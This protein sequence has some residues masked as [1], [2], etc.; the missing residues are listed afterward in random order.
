ME[1]APEIEELR[2]LPIFFVVGMGRSGTT[3]LRTILDAHPHTVV[4]VESKFVIHLKNKYKC[5]NQWTPAL[6]ENFII[7]LYG[8]VKFK[9]YWEMEYE[10]LRAFILQYDCK[11]LDFSLLCKMVYFNHASVFNKGKPMIIGD[12]NPVYSLFINDLKEVF[13]DAKF[14]HLVRDY[15]DTIVSN[16]KY[17]QRKN[18][19]AL[20]QVWA[21]YN[22]NIED[23][24]RH[25]R[26]KFYT[27]RYEDLVHDP[28]I[29]VKEICHFLGIEFHPVMLEFYLKTR[30]NYGDGKHPVVGL[31]F[32][33]LLN[34]VNTNQ[35]GKWKNE[36]TQKELGL[37]HFIDNKPG[38]QYEYV[39][40]PASF[41]AF[42]YLRSVIGY[43]MAMVD[44]A[45][46]K[47]YYILPF[48]AR[49]MIRQSARFAFDYL[50]ILTVYN[51]DDYL[52]E[53]LK[54][55]KQKEEVQKE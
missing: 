22:K 40:T 5:I 46:V 38:Q 43:W 31:L 53:I 30:E 48:F 12:K 54:K 35:I 44:I 27:I 8:D 34:K 36:L 41:S 24:K 1:K 49:Q 50:G 16:R 19:G 55:K 32:P 39:S 52:K 20:A 14:I 3:L 9:R 11:L 42:Y 28:E 21:I 25:D 47:G 17:F 45:V 51:G 13:P 10:K 15:R 2:K 18:V 23:E 33:E 29:K 7:D 37:I 4:S 6:V 26:S